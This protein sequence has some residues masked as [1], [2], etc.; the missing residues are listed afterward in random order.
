MKCSVIQDLLPSYVDN[1]CSEDSK[2][3]VREHVA[4]CSSCKA[5]LEQMKNTELVAENVAEKQ[6]DYLK[7]IR[8][9]FT[10]KEWLGKLVLVILA[11]IAFA[12]LFAGGGGLLDYG[13]IPSVVFSILLFCS[14]CLAGNCRYSSGRKSAAVETGISGILF[15]FVLSINEYVVQCIVEWKNPFPFMGP[16]M[17]DMG[18]GYAAILKAAALAVVV[19]LLKNTFGKQ[20]N[21]FATILNITAISQIVYAN[22]WLYHMDTPETTLAAAH[23]LEVTQII[24]AIVGII[25]CALLLKLGKTDKGKVNL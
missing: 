24:L 13:R 10:L 6:I 11:V 12:G 8:N 2:E 4:G 18:P 22:D 7:K 25:S 14:A 19:V 17:Y 3:L 20:K 1:I 9:K 23:E 16:E 21:V 5:K 15:A